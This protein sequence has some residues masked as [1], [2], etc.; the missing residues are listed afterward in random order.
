[1]VSRAPTAIEEIYTHVLCQI[2]FGTLEVRLG[3]PTLWLVKPICIARV[4]LQASPCV[5]FVRVRVCV[6]VSVRKSKG[7]DSAG[8]KER[9]R[10]R[11]TGSVYE[12]MRS[13]VCVC[14]YESM[15]ADDPNVA[16]TL[17][18]CVCIPC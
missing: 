12:Q 8:W 1:M 4:K 18:V 14:V 9:E 13:C 6:S 17:T 7:K 3:E 5:P 16:S 2:L 15:Y 11:E 10:G